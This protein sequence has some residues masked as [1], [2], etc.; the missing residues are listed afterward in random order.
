MLARHS[1]SGLSKLLSLSRDSR[2][3]GVQGLV[4]LQQLQCVA[5]TFGVAAPWLISHIQRYVQ[6]SESVPDRVTD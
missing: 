3:H 2:K 4:D 1:L 6:W 5:V